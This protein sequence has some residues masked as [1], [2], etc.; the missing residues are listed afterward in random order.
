MDWG[1]GGSCKHRPWRPQDQLEKILLAS[2]RWEKKVNR[3]FRNDPDE[4]S[5][6]KL[7]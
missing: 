5:A 1:G 2:K 3:A 4:L 7:L 6:Q